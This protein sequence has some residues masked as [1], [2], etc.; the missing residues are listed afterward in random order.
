MTETHKQCRVCEQLLTFDNYSGKRNPYCKECHSY[1]GHV[2]NVK[3]YGITPDE[4]LTLLK[5]QQYKCYICKK[6]TEKRLSVDHNNACC[7]GEKSCGNCIRG[8]LCFECN[9]ALGM[10]KDNVDTLQSMIDYLKIF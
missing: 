4:Y 3:K 6:K 5:E 1:L 8:L 7:A 9:I 2:R 10:V